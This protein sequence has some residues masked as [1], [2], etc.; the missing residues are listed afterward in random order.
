M[1]C[2]F[3]SSFSVPSHFIVTNETSWQLRNLNVAIHQG[4]HPIHDFYFF[5]LQ[6]SLTY[7]VSVRNPYVVINF[8][9]LV[10]GTLFSFQRIPNN[11]AKV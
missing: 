5:P 4:R 9:I 2:N 3:V 11:L 1:T 7:S 8:S 10:Y 6:L